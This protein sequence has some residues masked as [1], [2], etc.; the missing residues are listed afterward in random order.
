M[1]Y[2]RFPINVMEIC[3][4]THAKILLDMVFKLRSTLFANVMDDGRRLN[5]KTSAPGMGIPMLQIRRSR[6][7][8][9]FNMRIL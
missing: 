6:D 5:I 3:I 9:I 2:T 4:I 8:L 7:R 1:D